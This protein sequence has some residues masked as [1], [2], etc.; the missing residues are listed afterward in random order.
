[1]PERARRLVCLACIALLLGE[2]ACPEGMPHRFRGPLDEGL[3]EEGRTV[4]APVAPAWLATP[5]RDRGNACE[6]WQC[7]GGRRAFALCATGHE[8]PGSA[9]GASAGERL[10]QGE[11]GMAL[12]M[13]R[14]GGVAILESREGGTER[15]DEGLHEQRL[16]RDDA[17]IGGP[18]GRRLDGVEALGNHVRRAHMVLA[19]EALQGRAAGQW[20]GLQGGPAAEKVTTHDGI[21]VLQPSES[22]NLCGREAPLVDAS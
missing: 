6:R 7:G 1:M 2:D 8:E 22:C 9:D 21:F 19:K 15:T 4:A 10:G 5:F 14:D 17:L 20:C 16:G 11:V 3:T 18:G 13:L 12:G